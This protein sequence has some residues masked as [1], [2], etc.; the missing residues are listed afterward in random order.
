MPNMQRASLPR[1]QYFAVVAREGSL[2]RAARVLGTTHS[3]LSMQMRALEEEL[4]GSLL[5]RQG[6]GLVLT[7]FGHEV[8]W[9]ADEVSRLCLELAESRPQR[10]H[11]RR[12]PLRVGV[13]AAIPKALVYRLLEPALA[14]ST[15]ALGFGPLIATQDTTERLVEQLALGHLHLVLADVPP[16][17]GTTF[18][19]FGHAL[20][21]SKVSLYATRKLARAY[22]GSLPHSLEGAP[23]L[24]PARGTTLRTLIERWLAASGTRVVVEGEFADAGLLRAFGMNGHGI[25]PVRAALQAELADMHEVVSLGEIPDLSERYYAIS[26][27]R[28]VRHPAVNALIESARRGL[29]SGTVEPVR[30]SRRRPAAS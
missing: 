17:Q 19:L 30:S 10:E 18:R 7:A 13:V 27:E 4:G 5:E 28:R 3:N 1:L 9:Y 24:L 20:G 11:T 16:P 25:F 6:R 8:R 21:A 12:T 14:L 23:L 22:R 2:S 15:P 29:A 26:V